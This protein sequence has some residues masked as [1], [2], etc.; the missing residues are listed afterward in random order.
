MFIVFLLILLLSG[1]ISSCSSVKSSVNSSVEIINVGESFANKRDVNL[2]K[3]A[4]SVEYI[5]LETS[6]MSM[7]I[8]V[9]NLKLRCLGD[10]VYIYDRNVAL[11]RPTCPVL[12]FSS[13]GK[14]IHPV[15]FLGNSEREYMN[16]KDVIVNDATG[17]LVVVDWAKLIFYTEDGGYKRT[18]EV[19]NS[20]HMPIFING[21]SNRYMC[22]KCPT[23]FDDEHSYD[24][25][26]FIDSLGRN[27]YRRRM[28]RLPVMHMP[29]NGMPAT[30]GYK[31]SSIYKSDKGWAYL[32]S[33]KDSLYIINPDNGTVSVKYFVDYGKYATDEYMGA[34]LWPMEEGVCDAEKFIALKVLYNK[35]TFPQIDKNYLRSNVIYD[36]S[37]KTT[38]TLRYNSDY[39]LAG[40]TNDLDGG[41]P[42]YPIYI[43]DDK[44]YQ[45]LDAIDF[46]EYAEVSNSAKMKEVAATLTEESNP[47]LVVVTLK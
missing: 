34:G 2:S 12:C 8:G 31:S 24:E 7:L 17:E 40:F 45:M 29:F 35:T 23:I 46:I 42:F 44:M 15:G 27:L 9:R 20:G 32:Y 6:P 19:E 18:A 16:I 38:I 1:C 26:L 13:T 21:G 25:I 43:K 30:K 33:C 11:A 3:Y 36:K 39:N 10:N 41:M 37:A 47:V 14:F 28:P 5:P 22:Y 4:T